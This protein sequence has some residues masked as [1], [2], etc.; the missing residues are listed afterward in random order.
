MMTRSENRG[1]R[2]LSNALTRFGPTLAIVA[3]LLAMAFA[4]FVLPRL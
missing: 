4:L 3:M 1:T 2:R